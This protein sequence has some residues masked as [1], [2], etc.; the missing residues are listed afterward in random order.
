MTSVHET[1][2]IEVMNIICMFHRLIVGTCYRLVLKH[3]D[4]D[5]K[6]NIN[7]EMI[8]QVMLTYQNSNMNILVYGCVMG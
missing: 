5:I 7:V 3:Q 1:T 6:D 4:M 8:K 2:V